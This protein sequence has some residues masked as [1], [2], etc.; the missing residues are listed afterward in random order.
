M[1]FVGKQ[2]WSDVLE[3]IKNRTGQARFNLWFRNTELVSCSGSKLTIGVPT[4]FIQDWLRHHFTDLVKECFAALTGRSVR[5]EFL[6][7]PKLFQKLRQ[8]ELEEKAKLV[9]DSTS[10]LQEPL[11]RV[12]VRAGQGL[13][14]RRLR[15]DNFVTG[16]CNSLAYAAA[17]EVAN[18]ASNTF[19]PLFIYGSTGLGKTHLLQ[20]ICLACSEAD[21]PVQAVYVSG[22][23]FRNQYLASFRYQSV[24]AFRAHFRGADLLAVDDVHFLA[25]E[26]GTQK[27]FLYTLNDLTAANKQV[28]LAGNAHPSAIN[29]LEKSLASRFLAGMV[30]ELRPP[31]VASRRAILTSKLKERGKSCPQE[32]LNF[33]SARV[34]GSVR[35]LQ[36]IANALAALAQLNGKEPDIALACQALNAL[37]GRSRSTLTMETIVDKVAEEFALKPEELYSSRRTQRISLPRQVALYL[38]RQLLGWSY[39][40]LS[41]HFGRKDHSSAIFACKKVAALLKKDSTL[42]QI[43]FH[44][45]NELK[46]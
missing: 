20:G 1:T 15:L 28:V 5:V 34:E 26:P 22:E 21:R 25:N 19:N 4:T 9:A 18:A 39:G 46:R 24:D 41:R 44:L 12:P 37:K 27:E 7:A 17:C 14:N 8:Q 6:V 40:E 31:D 16:P 2:T 3:E 45:R 10:S 43:V 29:N 13:L 33:L 35:E 42:E 23:S 38:G 36:G 32:V 11:P 30:V